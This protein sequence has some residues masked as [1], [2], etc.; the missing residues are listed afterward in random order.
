MKVLTT[1]FLSAACAVLALQAAPSAASSRLFANKQRT[2]KPSFPTPRTPTSSTI[3][4][5]QQDQPE[6]L[7]Q[8]PRGVAS[9]LLQVLS[10]PSFLLGGAAY[11]VALVVACKSTC[12]TPEWILSLGGL[13]VSS[14]Y[15]AR[16]FRPLTNGNIR[17]PQDED[18]PVILG[19][20][21]F[22]ASALPLLST[23]LWNVV[24]SPSL[25]LISMI[26]MGVG[27]IAEIMAHF[28]DGW[29][30]RSG[31]H[32]ADG[33]ENVIF[34][35]CLNSGIALAAASMVPSAFSV[36]LAL[37]PG[38]LVASIPFTIGW[39]N[40]K[41][42]VYGSQGV[43]SGVAT[44]VFCK[45]LG[46]YWPLLFMVQAFN[47]I[48][49]AKLILKTDVQPLHVGPSVYGWFSYVVPFGLA[50][51]KANTSLPLVLATCMLTVFLSSRFETEIIKRR[52]LI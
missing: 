43:T 17:L 29:V 47:I 28:F 4:V 18:F 40:G 3:E 11:Y 13:A 26:T 5:Q 22:S 33:T 48:R 2:T 12:L 37:T 7:A 27:N 41:G 38:I 50:L 19:A 16:S 14:V 36:A 34:S 51:T 42:I 20:H 25:L 35:A 39:K 32:A 45:K 44:W 1:S 9:K 49:N 10:K 15:F 21:I 30:F 23:M 46:S 24:N 8:V 6:A 52:S 31:G